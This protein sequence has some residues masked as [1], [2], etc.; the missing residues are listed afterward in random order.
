MSKTDF[1]I[2]C[3]KT[4]TDQNPASKEH[5]IPEA[6]GNEKIITFNVCE[7]CNNRLGTVVDSYLTDY[8]AVKALRRLNLDKD[9]DLPVFRDVLPDEHGIKHKVRNEGAQRLATAE[10]AEMDNGAVHIHVD[11]GNYEEG[12]ALAKKK[13]KRIWK[14]A[15]DEEIDAALRKDG[16]IIR[17]E[18]Q[19][20]RPLLRQDIDIDRSRWCMAGIKMAYEYASEKL[21]LPYLT[22]DIA[23]MYRYYLYK[24]VQGN[25]EY[26]DEEF[27]QFLK[28][29][30][31]ADFKCDIQ[32]IFD[33]YKNSIKSNKIYRI[34]I[35]NNGDNRL[36]CE[37]NIFDEKLLSFVIVLSDDAQRYLSSRKN[38]FHSEIGP[39]GELKEW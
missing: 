3:R 6:L 11:T 15:S 7:H 31:I 28:Y 4:F 24:A 13:L 19:Y 10:A 26:S 34:A 36:V 33:K 8:I 20:Y 30:T 5:I 22:D 25:K 21:G 32:P 29:C 27:Q 18:T 17:G 2:I 39:D 35:K 1:C 38:G 9:R 12:I 14:D 37:I 23:C 16:A